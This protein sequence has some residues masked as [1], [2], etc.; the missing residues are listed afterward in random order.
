MRTLNVL[1]LP[2]VPA[3]AILAVLNV[4]G[5][6]GPW[7]ETPAD[8][9]QQREE[10]RKMARET[11]E[12]Y[13]RLYGDTPPERWPEE[14]HR[15]IY[16]QAKRVLAEMGGAVSVSHQWGANFLPPPGLESMAPSED[17]LRNSNRL[18]ISRASVSPGVVSRKL[19]RIFHAGL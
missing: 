12:K 6:I 18:V 9:K 17:S 11:V 5:A 15:L 14:R 13:H 2:V 16:R 19:H 10:L 4:P 3:L 1:A 8:W 7:I